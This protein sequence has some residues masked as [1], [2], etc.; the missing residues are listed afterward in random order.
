LRWLAQQHSTLAGLKCVVRSFQWKHRLDTVVETEC[1]RVAQEAL[2]NVVRHARAKAVTVALHKEDGQIHLRVRDDGIGFDV[3]A[4]REK[5]LRG[6]TRGI[7][8]MEARTTL[9]G[10]GLEFTSIL[11]QG[12]EVHAW[13]PLKWP[14][15][16]PNEDGS[17]R[18]ANA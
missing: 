11:K 16:R 4:V 2:L 12:T 3:A 10:G 18:F 8:S 14:A 1:F 9:A 6:A 15:N 5:A 13:F 7:L 17:A